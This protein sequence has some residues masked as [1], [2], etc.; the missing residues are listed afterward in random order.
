MEGDE[1]SVRWTIQQVR[2]Q[3]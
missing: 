3:V 1:K 2:S